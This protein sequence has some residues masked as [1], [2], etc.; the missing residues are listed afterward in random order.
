MTRWAQAPPVI[1][2]PALQAGT[3]REGTLPH[4][5]GTTTLPWGQH[6]I[7]EGAEGVCWTLKSPSL[8]HE[9]P[10]GPDET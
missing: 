1:W 7:W 9:P 5:H 3:G 2:C 10:Q 8:G 6:S 4:C